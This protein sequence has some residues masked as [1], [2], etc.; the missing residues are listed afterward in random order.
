[1][2]IKLA[3]VTTLALIVMPL[4]KAVASGGKLI[5][6]AGLMQVEGVGGGGLV[7]WATLS[8]YDTRD[9][10]S[11]NAVATRVEVNDYRLSVLA[12]SVSLYDRLEISIAQQLLDVPALSSQIEQHVFGLK[13]RVYGDVVYSDY[14]QLSLGWQHKKLK[15]GAI[16]NAL[17]AEDERS[18]NDVYIA[19]T[20]VHLAAIAGYNAL[21]N[22]TARATKANQMGLLGFGSVDD[23]RYEI[24]L[25]ASAGI[26]FSRHV[27]VGIEFRQK[28]DNLGIGEEHAKD[29]FF[30]YIP[31]KAFNITLAWV[32]LGSIAGAPNQQGIY[33][34]LNGSL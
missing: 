29:L 5:A 19:A 14:P 30:S 12:A 33:L 15:D 20:K 6:T 21:W 2:K 13:Y 28:P 22:L 32:D 17:G 10:I 25:E 16:A 3:F 34:S 4:S 7:P 27:A 11:L 8:G 18:G 24:M 31:S 23:D 26:L 9:E 1:M